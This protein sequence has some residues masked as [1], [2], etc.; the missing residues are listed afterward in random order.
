MATAPALNP[1]LPGTKPESQKRSFEDFARGLSTDFGEATYYTMQAFYQAWAKNE[2]YHRGEQLITFDEFTGM[3]DEWTEEQKDLFHVV[4]Y[5]LPYVEMNAVEY[6]KSDPK[7][8]T[9]TTSGD[10]RRLT[11]AVEQAQYI[12]DCLKETLWNVE[13][14]QR[15]GH[16]VQFRGQVYTRTYRDMFAKRKCRKP[17][18]EMV[19]KKLGQD[20]LEC[21][22]CGWHG[23]T[24]NTGMTGGAL[25]GALPSGAD[26]NAQASGGD[27]SAIPPDASAPPV[28]QSS[29]PTGPPCPQCGAAQTI[30]HPAPVAKS[31][32]QTGVDLVDTWDV[33]SPFIDPFE[34][35]TWD[36][37]LTPEDSP[38]LEWE[39][40]ELTAKV[41]A[42]FKHAKIGADSSG[43]SNRIGGMDGLTFKRMLELSAGNDTTANKETRHSVIGQG[44]GRS[45]A[46]VTDKLTCRRKSAYYEWYVYQ[47]VVLE[48]DYTIPHTGK[49]IVADVPLGKQFPDGLLIEYANGEILDVLN[50]EKNSEWSGYK[51][52]VTGAGA[53]GLGIQNGISMQ[54]W[55]NEM[56]SYQLTAIAGQA[57]GITVV[58]GGLL[59]EGDIDMSPPA[60]VVVE[61][62]MPGETLQSAL[63]HHETKGPGVEAVGMQNM[64]KADMQFTLG[65]RASSVTGL[66]GPEMDTATGV[67]YQEATSDAFAGMRL[68]LAAWNKARRLEQAVAICQK[69]ET[70]PVYRT[71][72][73]ETKGKW[74]AGF[75]I[76]GDI[77]VRVE[78][79]SHQPRTQETRK[80]DFMAARNA[81]Y[82]DPNTPPPLQREIAKLFNQ[83]NYADQYEDWA[84]IGEK[85]LDLIRDTL[86]M[87]KAQGIAPE[88]T[89]MVIFGGPAVPVSPD[90]TPEELAMVP[91]LP[92]I[93]KILPDVFDNH[94]ALVEFYINEFWLSDEGQKIDE[95]FDTVLHQLVSLHENA[96]V[97]KAQQEVVKQKTV[98]AP[99]ESA[100]QEQQDKDAAREDER[101][102]RAAN[103]EDERDERKRQHDL[104]V[105]K[106]KEKK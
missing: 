72:W 37:A 78:P 86:E 79:D 29:V 13:E 18:Y 2:L 4:N 60:I 32:T 33:R 64:M 55:A 5:I 88:E 100:Q 19:D 90:A 59:K 58:N 69:F 16:I 17:R 65:A 80:R 103:R 94:A 66:P 22:G 35:R 63:V 73:G 96:I 85:R 91:M 61:D 36:R 87:C 40:V 15:E 42:Q 70:Y 8:V 68:E 27:Q 49:V 99:I 20:L 51:Y 46:S 71:K 24:G 21:T 3:W 82:G 38:F 39:R 81:G 25:G 102:E 26:A 62:L 48:E 75:S 98:E 6:S 45:N 1:S 52:I 67:T 10:E 104:M 105:T 89:M 31:M 50:F 14:K 56:N 28:K 83:Q 44:F 77:K 74:L 9:Y 84:M 43:G 47:D 41:K 95:I 106:L 7:F 92:G 30:L 12:V 97:Q 34:V 23:N 93:K 76:P 57:N 53:Q 54:D 11:A 101:T